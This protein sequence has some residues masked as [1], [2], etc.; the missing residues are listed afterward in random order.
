M[1]IIDRLK[2]GDVVYT[3]C[4]GIPLCYHLGIVIDENGNKMVMH[5]SP[6]IRNKNGGSVCYEKYEN[7]IKDR[8]LIKVVS[9]EIS[10]ERILHV[11]EK[12]KHAIW[13][14]FDFNCEDFIVE[15]VEGRKKSDLRDAWKFA[16]LGIVFL[17]LLDF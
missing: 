4:K 16:A 3:D 9:T 12:Y 17:F 14:T 1:K 15:I 8:N 2:T 5:N 13:D 7:F 10:E 11:S 6:S